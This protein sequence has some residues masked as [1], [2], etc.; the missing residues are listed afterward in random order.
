MAL[1]DYSITYTG[2][3]DAPSAAYPQ[4]KMRNPS[5]EGA[6]DETPLEEKWVNDIQGFLQA[7]LLNAGITPSDVVETALVSDYFN[8]L[9]AAVTSTLDSRT[10]GYVI[11][12]PIINFLVEEPLPDAGVNISALG[13]KDDGTKMY[14][15]GQ[16]DAAV[17]QYSMSTAWDLSTLSYDSVLLSVSG[18]DSAMLGMAFKDDGTKMYLTGNINN[19]VYQ[20]SLSTAWDLS[21][22]S[23]DSV[24]LVVTAQDPTPGSLAFKD[25][26]TKMYVLGTTNDAVYQYSLTAWDLSTASY[27]SVSFSVTGQET[28]PTGV[29]FNLDGTKM[30]VVGTTNDN[31]HQYSLSTPWDLTTASYD[32]VS[33]SV[34]TED[35]SPL[36]LVFGKLGGRLFIPGGVSNAA[37]SYNSGFIGA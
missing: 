23:Y 27:D 1:L 21:S 12:A 14:V 2:G 30:F 5:T 34:A 17:Y 7:I 22:A 37:I 9:L 36:D 15:L 33:F 19:S 3:A 8:G 28:N 4:G 18:Q 32:S 25:D 29:T 20:Y 31:V 6:G 10:V 35:T 24:T 26:G 13:F 16:T 11:E